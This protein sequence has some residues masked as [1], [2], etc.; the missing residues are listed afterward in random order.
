VRTRFAAGD[1]VV[2]GYRL[3]DRLGEG[4]FGE[5]WKA[6]GPGGFLVAMKLVPL[7]DQ[8]GSVEMR[9]LEVIKQVRHPQLLAVFGAW[10]VEGVLAVAM[11]L[12]ERTLLDRFREA[13][14]QGFSGIPA[15][16]IHELFQ[17]AARG[18]DYL[19]EPR[20]PSGGK[21]PLG[22]QHRDVKPQN[23]LLM[24]GG[25]KVADFGLAR[26]L[27]HSL[28]KHTGSLTPAYAA[29]EFFRNETSSQSDQYSLAVTYCHMRSGQ[30]PFDG[31][32]A[33]IMAGHLMMPPDLSV[34]PEA[35]RAAVERALA[36]DS[37]DRW[38]TCRAFVRALMASGETRMLPRGDEV[39]RPTAPPS[40]VFGGHPPGSMPSPETLDPR[41][42]PGP[43]PRVGSRPAPADPAPARRRRRLLSTAALVALAALGMAAWAVVNWDRL[44]GPGRD[45]MKTGSNP[46]AGGDPGS[47]SSPGPAEEEPV[48]RKKPEGSPV[49]S[50][51]EATDD[52][53]PKDSPPSKEAVAVKKA[54]PTDLIFT[55]TLGMELA[56]IPAGEFLMGSSDPDKDARD[57]EKPQHRVHILRSF[58][59]G[60]TEV[61]RSQFRRFVEAE[62]Y[63]TEAERDGKGGF[64]WDEEKKQFRQ[65]PRYTW[66]E[67]GFAQDDEHPVANVSRNDAVAFCEW[68]GKRESCTYRLPT[69][70]EW[71]YA[72]RAGTTT[73]YSSGDD[74]EMLGT[75]GN[76]ADATAKE[77][78]PGWITIAARDGYVYTAPVGQFRKNAFG[79]YDMHGNVWELCQDGYQNDVIRGGC[80][81][82]DPSDV[83]SAYRGRLSPGFRNFGVG[84]RVARV[85]SE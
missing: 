51:S 12:A 83:R 43:P 26:V 11:E 53:S 45:G 19:N 59:L 72:C 20:H 49:A 22:I 3:I 77:K 2:P 61:T 71:E 46:G 76:V 60:A 10:Q 41:R 56:Q 17:D 30:L 80:W 70:A 27:Q 6:E 75:V 32:L 31:N 33:S 34:L 78:Y 73:R 67:P 55:N 1:E 50:I 40:P 63:R 14:G 54:K 39:S 82:S 62:R 24:G 74:P 79:L 68:L 48:D 44:T 23:L 8:A 65:D 5:V 18:L 84:F 15:P 85:R 57:R 81:N 28:T 4:G 7:G 47:P 38:P 36:K 16:E 69:E 29:P 9:A 35:E 25:V 37:K 58:Y 52:H 21:E 42:D 64:G 13:V 66:L